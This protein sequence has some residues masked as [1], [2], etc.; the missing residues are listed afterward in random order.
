MKTIRRIFPLLAVLLMVLVAVGARRV[1][2]DIPSEWREEIVRE[3]YSK[4]A[5]RVAVGG[6]QISFKIENLRTIDAT[7]FDTVEWLDLVTLPGGRGPGN[8]RPAR[9]A[10]TH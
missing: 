10:F 4:L 8:D 9:A 1:G 2:R 3:A 6:D 7:D 5:E